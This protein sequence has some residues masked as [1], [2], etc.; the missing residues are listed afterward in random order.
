MN[1]IEEKQLEICVRYKSG[2]VPAAAGSK[3]GLALQTIGTLPINGLR[4]RPQRNTNGW[5]IWCG[6]D[7]SDAPDFFS[8]LHTSH[9]EEYCPEILPYLGLPPGYRFLV[10]GDHVDVWFDP[11]LL[12]V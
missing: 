9:V 1:A 2:F 4:H 7:L 8:P 11:K 3:L 5:Y 12:D 10:S 6:T